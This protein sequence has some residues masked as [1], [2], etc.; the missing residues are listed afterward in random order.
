MPMPKL[1]K[2]SQMTPEERNQE[3]VEIFARALARIKFPIPEQA[4][5]PV[6]NQEQSTKETLCKQN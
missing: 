5:S 3:L 1:P 2:P 4:T 6:E